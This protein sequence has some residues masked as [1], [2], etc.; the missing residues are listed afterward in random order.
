MSRLSARRRPP[1]LHL[2]G[3]A[4]RTDG[5]LVNRGHIQL[6]ERHLRILETL[7]RTGSLNEA[8]KKLGISYR[9]AWQKLRQAEA[10]F[11]IA[12]VEARRGGDGGGG[13]RLTRAGEELL[14]RLRAFRDEQQ[15]AAARAAALHLGTS[16]RSAS[17]RR[18]AGRIV[19]ATTTSAVDSGLL[20]TLLP[21]F[22]QRLGI[23]VELLAVGSGRA[24]QLAAAGRADAVL[25]HAP[26]AEEHALRAGHVVGRFPMM[27][28]RFVLV[29]PPDDPAGVR[30]VSDSREALRRIAASSA[31]FLSRAD[32]SGT[33]E[34]ERMLLTAAGLRAGRWHRRYVAGMGDLLAQASRSLAYA[35]ADQGTFAAL[36]DRLDL[37]ILFEIDDA[38]RNVYSILAT[39]PYR[40]AEVDHV[41]AMAL[42]G[43]LTSPAAQETIAG[44]R[45]G[46]RS[47]AQPIT[48][49]RGRG[50]PTI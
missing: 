19:L 32:G 1:Q 13:S 20:G 26:A 7:E 4:V 31:S 8:A 3:L 10:A 40:R 41:V 50:S 15:Q 14:S 28:N 27:T 16:R 25:A 37:A 5:W 2:S 24:L 30:G 45:V 9:D 43:W 36:A 46:G 42:V 22:R 23:E 38:L 49:R 11:G 33:H 21:P 29:G 47:I 39:N 12:L 35:L 34:C 44:Y 17:R 6:G 18:D 48:R